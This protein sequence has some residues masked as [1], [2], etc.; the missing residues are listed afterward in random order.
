MNF[1]LQQT[2]YAVSNELE[3]CLISVVEGQSRTNAENKDDNARSAGHAERQQIG[4]GDRLRPRGTDYF[5]Q[6]LLQ[7]FDKQRSLRMGH[8]HARM[9]PDKVRRALRTR[10]WK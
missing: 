7:I 6:T 3:E 8:R 4:A 9:H 10:G 1:A 5:A 2:G